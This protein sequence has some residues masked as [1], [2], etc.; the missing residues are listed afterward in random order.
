M[1]RYCFERASVS[2]LQNEAISNFLT[3][4]VLC[5][6]IISPVHIFIR[7]LSPIIYLLLLRFMVLM[8]LP[9]GPFRI[10]S[11]REKHF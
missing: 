7:T 5:L 10:F 4:F 11:I 2:K 9:P 1:Y 3:L 6:Y 8:D